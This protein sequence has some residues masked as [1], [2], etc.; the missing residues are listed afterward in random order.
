M[1]HISE[2]KKDAKIKLTGNYIRCASSSLLYFIMI[3]LI[4]FFQEKVSF[5]IKNSVLLAII[6]AIFLILSWILNYGII[7]NILDLVNIKT[8]SITDF[9][10]STLKFG[11]KYIK[12]GLRILLK[13]LLPLILFLF[14]VFY[15]IGTAIAN[16]NQINFL[17]FNKDLL[18]LAA[19]I[20]IISGILLLYYI[21]KYVLVA[22]IYHENLEMPDKDIVNKSNELM[23]GNKLKYILLL[24]SFLHW[25]LF[26]AIALLL[27]NI[28]IEA[29]YL[30]PFMVLFYSIIRP[31]I[32]TSKSEFYTELSDIKEE[33]INNN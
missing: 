5:S 16:V 21:L 17:C 24:L 25:F 2:I 10:N 28:F 13:I 19:L 14:S 31:Y 3:S 9:I 1:M 32:V 6:E 4:T 15:W 18:P 27:L 30:T 20:W 7:S 12:I 33:K 23:Q 22:Y 11:G 26:G 29:K 8:N